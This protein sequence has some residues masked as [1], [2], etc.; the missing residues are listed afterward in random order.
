[1]RSLGL[2]LALV[3]TLIGASNP[4]AGAGAHSY[5]DQTLDLLRQ[6][7]R[8]D[9]TNPPGN[10]L[11]AAQFLKQALL[12]EGIEARIDEFAPGR[13]NVMARLTGSGKKRPIIL[14]S[15]L[16]VVPADASRWKVP[17]FSAETRDGAIWARGSEDMKTE[18]ILQLMTVIRLKREAVPLDRDVIFMGTADEEVDF[19]G[20]LR[21]LSPEG[22]GKELREAE[23]FVTEGGDNLRG[24]DGKPVYF[25]VDTGEKGVFWLKLKTTGTPGHG[26]RPIADSALNRM[27]RALD[28]IR[29]YKTQ[30][31]VLPSVAKLFRDQAA[32]TKGARGDWYKD[33][34][35]AIQ[36]PAVAQ[37]LYDD[38]EVSALFRNTIS[39][40]VVN[41]GYKTNVIPGTAEAELDV[42]LL[43]GEDPEA[44]LA[45]LGKVIDDPS[46]EIV[47]RPNFRKP[48][49]SPTDTELFHGIEAALGR[50][51]PGVPVT[52]KLLSGATEGVLFR[53]AGLICYGFTPLL[54]LRDEAGTEHG[55]D[56]RINEATVRESVSVFY[57]AIRDFVERR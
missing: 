13:A 31:K 9:T 32:R 4:P 8:I 38:R 33:V 35:K 57:E 44:F 47:P 16:D 2:T 51:Y 7:L 54:P 19:L 42:R 25:G 53:E 22:W 52:T 56:E 1:M 48:N 49:E 12:A 36:D 3:L 46:V 11:L 55:D 34:A 23:Y 30:M 43:P 26:S 21:A 50:R 29:L 20:A 10:E 37:V 5:E 14:S 45:E 24:D 41:A 18:G 40:T 17:P 6:Y 15:H 27:I 28:R 39:I